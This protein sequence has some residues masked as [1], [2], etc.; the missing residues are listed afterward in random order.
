V[1]TE[2]VID[3][4]TEKDNNITESSNPLE[5]RTPLV[6]VKEKSLPKR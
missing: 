5:K 6:K 3:C 1:A 2:E 4:I